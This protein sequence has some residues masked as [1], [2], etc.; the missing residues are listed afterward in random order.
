MEINEC[1][2]LPV[3]QIVNNSGGFDLI[4]G[5]DKMGIVNV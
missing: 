4:R 5:T 2:E 1:Q 3:G